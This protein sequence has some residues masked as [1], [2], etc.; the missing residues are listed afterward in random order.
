MLDAHSN[1][2][3]SNGSDRGFGIVF[4]VI[5]LVVALYPLISGGSIRLWAL[6]VAAA[7]LTPTPDVVNL[8][9]FAVPTIGL[10]LLG[11]GAAALTTRR[12]RDETS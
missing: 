3:L 8:C 7:F 2:K 6:T 1:I 11:V 12:K 4:A 5:F 10:Y 9:L